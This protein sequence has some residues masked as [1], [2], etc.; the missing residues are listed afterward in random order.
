MPQTLLP[1]PSRLRSHAA[2][3][4]SI[5]AVVE[6]MRKHFKTQ[7]AV[8]FRGKF[9]IGCPIRR[10][11]CSCCV[12]G[13]CVAWL[14]QLHPLSKGIFLPR[15]IEMCIDLYLV[16]K[17]ESCEREKGVGDVAALPP[18]GVVWGGFV[19]SYWL[20]VLFFRCSA[21]VRLFLSSFKIF[22]LYWYGAVIPFLLSHSDALC[23]HPRTALE[24][25]LLHAYTFR[26]FGLWAQNR[27]FVLNTEIVRI[28][29]RFRAFVRNRSCV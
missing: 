1:P 8:C 5:F 28:S 12:F 26:P 16:R 3:V 13:C 4:D 9:R 19:V 24:L 14:S 21:S 17:V 27:M 29:V 11:F 6:M 25:R 18:C 15:R 2:G 23:C 7:F 10:F 22:I 20:L